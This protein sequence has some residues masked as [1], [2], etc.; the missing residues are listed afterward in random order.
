LF[1]FETKDF[2]LKKREKEEATG[3]FE[4]GRKVEAEWRE[5]IRN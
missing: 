5:E 2:T 1:G 4:M 3:T